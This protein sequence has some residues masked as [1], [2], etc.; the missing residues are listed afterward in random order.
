[1]TRMWHCAS[2]TVKALRPA[3]SHHDDHD[4]LA[5]RDRRGAKKPRELSDIR[6][7][8]KVIEERRASIGVTA[9]AHRGPSQGERRV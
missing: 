7:P 1:M 9:D 8:V 2:A 4:S 5:G 3:S 6:S